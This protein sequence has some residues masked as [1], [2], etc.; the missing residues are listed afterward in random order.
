M[1]KRII[2]SLL[3]IGIAVAAVTGATIAYFTDVATSTGNT[4]TAGTLNIEFEGGYLPVNITN[5]QPGEEKLIRFDVRNTGSLDAF[6]A[7]YA[8]GSW[9]LQDSLDNNLMQVSKVE[10]WNEGSTSWVPI[11]TA[12]PITGI[13]YYSP[14]GSET[15]LYTLAASQTE[16]FQLTVK[17]D[18]TADN[19]Y[20]GKTYTATI[21]VGA[22]QTTP[23]ATW[24]SF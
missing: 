10:Y 9:N 22:K 20:Q 12:D 8:T 3:M 2:F 7:A 11:K 14:D 1:T 6:I 19:A 17:L 18:E 5:M 13:V 21:N 4:L 23:G 16:Q 15:A 24:P